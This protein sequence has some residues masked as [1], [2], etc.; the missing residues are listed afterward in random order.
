MNF[1]KRIAYIIFAVTIISGCEDLMTKKLDIDVADYPPQLAV[2]A[3]LDTDSGCFSISMFAGYSMNYY[4]E[5]RPEAENVSGNGNIHLYMDDDSDPVLSFSGLFRL[6][7]TKQQYYFDGKDTIYHDWYSYFNGYDNTFFDI[8]VKA[9]SIYRLE[10]EIDGFPKVTSTAV[11]PDDP[12]IGDVVV[13]TSTVVTKNNPTA[14]WSLNSGWWW[15][16]SNHFWPINLRLTDNSSLPDYYSFSI[17]NIS[18]QTYDGVYYRNENQ[19]GIGTT[20]KT[21]I[22][23]NPDVEAEGMLIELGGTPRD[24]YVFEKMLISDAS[25]ANTSTYFPLYMIPIDLYNYTHYKKRPDYN[26]DIHGPENKSTEIIYLEVKHLS[27]ETFMHY[28]SLAQQWA[29][30]GILSEPVFIKSNIEN[31]WG[32]F[33]LS[34]TKRIK[35]LECDYYRYPEW[36]YYQA[37][38]NE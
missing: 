4:K 25:F 2:T 16:G 15:V 35:L 10:V 13:D 19:T 8:P 6:S 22:Q 23:D 24:I 7:G 18:T 1:K 32:C 20:N 26:P 9:G 14:I 27:K 12:I 17:Y 31:G 29:G 11:M 21:L 37:I 3:I 36:Y 28:R 38:D 5:W 30:G 34:N 33:S